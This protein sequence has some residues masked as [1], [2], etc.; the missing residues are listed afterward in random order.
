[1]MPKQIMDKTAWNQAL[2]EL[3]SRKDVVFVQ[4]YI[5][6]DIERQD[7]RSGEWESWKNAYDW[8]RLKAG[9]EIYA[10]TL[11]EV[12]DLVSECVGG[13][14]SDITPITLEYKLQGDARLRVIPV[15]GRF[16]DRL[17]AAYYAASGR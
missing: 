8:F 5:G 17:M 11:D 12:Y 3:T 4:A 1:M 13:E 2:S 14:A 7:P 16:I 15:D 10:K 6:L 9:T